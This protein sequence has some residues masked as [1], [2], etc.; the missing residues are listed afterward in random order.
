[1]CWEKGGENEE[2]KEEQVSKFGKVNCKGERLW[3]RDKEGDPLFFLG[4]SLV[5]R[6]TTI[7]TTNLKCI[8]SAQ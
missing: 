6:I 4:K 3:T 2:Q 8:V 1:M 5:S 7:H